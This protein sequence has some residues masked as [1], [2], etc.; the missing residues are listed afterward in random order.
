M[1]LRQALEATWPRSLLGGE[2]EAIQRSLAAR[3]VER[4]EPGVPRLVVALDL[5]FRR[6]DRAEHARAA[7]VVVSYPDL[8]VVER[9]V[10][11]EPV[12]FPYVPG[13]LAF[14]EAPA[15]LAVLAALE[16]TPDLIV[17]DGQGRLH[18]RRFGIACHVGV[19]VDR[20]TIGCAKSLLLRLEVPPL[21]DEPGARVALAQ[22]DERVGIALWTRKGV[23]PVY[24]SVGHRVTLDRAADLLWS[25]CR[26]HRL[27]EPQ[28]QAH[29]LA[30]GQLDVLRPSL[31]ATQATEAPTPPAKGTQLALWGDEP[32]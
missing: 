17:V 28:R 14:R 13:L 20:P 23:A 19:L 11:E 5:G 2:A 3:V 22:G 21:A 12:R 8:A 6:V 32:P 30:S 31:P 27:P 1:P 9:Q 10:A 18:P 16:T 7:A 29:L 15:M 24:V 4:D 26:G 25:L